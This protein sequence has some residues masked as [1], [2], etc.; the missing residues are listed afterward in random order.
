MSYKPG[1]FAIILICRRQRC[2]ITPG[3]TPIISA[4]QPVSA[5]VRPIWI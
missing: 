2:A 5:A 4:R 1:E 3:P